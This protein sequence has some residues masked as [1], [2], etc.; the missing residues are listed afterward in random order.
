MIMV[1]TVFTIGYTGFQISEF[2]ET[3]KYNKIS[4][5]IDVRSLPYSP[6]YLDYNKE[7]LSKVLASADIY[8]RNYALEFGARQEDQAY[9][10]RGYLDFDLFSKSKNFLSGIAK[11]EQSMQ[12]NYKFA[13]MCSEKDPV[14]CHRAIL[15]ARAFHLSGYNVMHL[16]PNGETTT[17]LKIEERLLDKFFPERAQLNMFEENLSLQEYLDAAYKKQN[18]GIGYMLERGA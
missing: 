2:I 6:Y 10:P 14:M 13:L 11:L 18:A 15:V 17:Q 3:L 4:L 16:L 1:N 5:V 12:Q 9:Y 8:Y 7:P